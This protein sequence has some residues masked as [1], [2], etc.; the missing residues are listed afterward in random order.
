VTTAAVAD[1]E[2]LYRARYA[3][4]ARVA[5]AITGDAAQGADAVHDAFASAIGSL[6]SYRGDAPLEAWV[7]RIVIRAA[8]AA[9]SRQPAP[10]APVG[11]NGHGPA[12]D[13]ADIRALVAALPERQRLAVFLRYFADLD[14]RAIAVALG[15]ETGTVSATLNA[16]HNALRRSLEE[17][18]L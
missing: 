6:R 16:A 13:G 17:A 7:W 15:V 3:A 11:S 4:F 8:Q 5:A 1:I 18:P 10:E 2:M 12:L 14:Y 9:R